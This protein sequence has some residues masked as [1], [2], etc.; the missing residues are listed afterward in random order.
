MVTVTESG[1][2]FRVDL[3]AQEVIGEPLGGS[4]SQFQN[5]AESPDGSRI[6]AVGRDGAL[7]LWDAESGRLISEKLEGSQATDVH[8]IDNQTILT[9]GFGGGFVWDLSTDRRISVACD[10]VGRQLTED[11]WTLFGDDLGDSD[12]CA[13]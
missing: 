8:F 7:R 1:L 6:A 2:A 3:E 9:N 4:V 13:G 5:V 10:L 11:E 12:A